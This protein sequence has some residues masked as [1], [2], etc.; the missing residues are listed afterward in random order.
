MH[1]YIHTHQ[2][3]FPNK[4]VLE[5][6]G[7]SGTDSVIRRNWSIYFQRSLLQ[8]D[9]YTHLP[10]KLSVFYFVFCWDKPMPQPALLYSLLY[11]LK[12]LLNS[13]CL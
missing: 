5:M 6:K 13:V 12:K 1:M 8:L 11:Q 2:V 3:K 4:K 7:F 10:F 9:K